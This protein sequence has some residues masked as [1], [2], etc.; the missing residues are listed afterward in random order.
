MPTSVWNNTSDE[1]QTKLGR[2]WNSAGRR[3]YEK[4]GHITCCK[5]PFKQQY[6]VYSDPG[7]ESQPWYEKGA[8][9][10]PAPRQQATTEVTAAEQ[11]NGTFETKTRDQTRPG[12]A[13]DQG[14]R[15]STTWL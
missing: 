13:Q 14:K 7:F 9:L 1:P 2:V 12:F 6:H 3:N 5:N 4:A 8:G 11:P 15:L 10:P